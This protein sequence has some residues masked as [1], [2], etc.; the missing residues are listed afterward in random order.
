MQQIPGFKLAAIDL[1][2][3]LLGQ[4]KEI[5]AENFRA[6]NRLREHGLEVL[7]ASG[8]HLSRMT[9]YLEQIGG[10]R[11]AVSCQGAAV[12]ELLGRKLIFDRP[13]V[14]QE[15]MNVLQDGMA[16]G[17]TVIVYA[18][19]GIY[20]PA[21]DA[22]TDYYG[23]ISG[24]EPVFLDKTEWER[25]TVYKVLW[26]GDPDFLDRA[27]ARDA[28]QRWPFYQVRTHEHIHEFMAPGV[29]K[30]PG[31]AAAAAAFGA[32]PGETVVFG[33]GN[34]DIPMFEW[35]GMSVA[36]EHGSPGAREAATLVTS[37]GSAGSAFA[38]GV[39]AFLDRIGSI[40]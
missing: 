5:G 9:R 14:H 30:G 6:L 25:K 3:T 35:A 32:M 1:D 11:W 28:V 2:E 22:W 7:I 4:D 27:S 10:M 17:A 38:R 23:S 16:I 8:R 33:D 18:A 39:N 21:P 40:V 19:D 36:M 29:S 34:N 13:M 20:A 37:P 24:G 12:W 26:L 31:L 15:A